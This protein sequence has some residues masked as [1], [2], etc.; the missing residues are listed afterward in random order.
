MAT[1]GK[2]GDGVF[3]AHLV[4]KPKV[5]GFGGEHPPLLTHQLQGCLH[6]HLAVAVLHVLLGDD[7]VDGLVALLLALQFIYESVKFVGVHH[8]PCVNVGGALVD[9]EG[10]VI[11]D[12]HL[13]TTVNEPR[14]GTGAEPDDV[15]GDVAAL[16]QHVADGDGFHHVAAKT[17]NLQHHLLTLRGLGEFVCET[18][19]GVAPSVYLAL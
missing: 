16:L 9:E 8:P 18:V 2:V 11:I 4:H 3:L 10:A 6:V 5:K 1:G 19:P 13:V 14:G 12:D 15:G 7:E 17:V